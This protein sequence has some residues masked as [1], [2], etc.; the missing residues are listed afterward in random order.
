MKNEKWIEIPGFNMY[1]ISTE[2][3]VFSLK[4]N[5]YLKICNTNN[6]HLNITL[7]NK[8]K[9][10]F[11]IHQLMAISFLEHI[12]DGHK[13]VVNH[14]N[15]DRHDNRL[16]N[17]ELCSNREN[18]SCKKNINKTSKFLGVSI[19][20]AN[21]KWVAQ[22]RYKDKNIKLGYYVKEEDAAKI[23]LIALNNLDKYTTDKEF[24]I[25]IKNILNNNLEEYNIKPY[26]STTI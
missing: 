20:R 16:E 5:K 8:K 7:Y 2:G 10:V 3:R 9:Y 13:I 25:L 26:K 23:Y 14:K 17:L 6:H 21:N 12:V 19:H 24:R 22:I 15:G 18:T 1:Q 4:T 11:N